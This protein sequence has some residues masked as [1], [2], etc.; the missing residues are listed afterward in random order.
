[1]QSAS[2]QIEIEEMVF[3]IGNHSLILQYKLVEMQSFSRFE[4]L[5]NLLS[6]QKMHQS[7]KRVQKYERLFY[8]DC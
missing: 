6:G 4:P 3:Q 8:D 2:I 7:I 1:M 5:E